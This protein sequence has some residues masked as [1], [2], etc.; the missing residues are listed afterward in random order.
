MKRSTPLSAPPFRIEFLGFR[1]CL[2]AYDTCEGIQL[3]I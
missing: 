1:K 2:L 3:R